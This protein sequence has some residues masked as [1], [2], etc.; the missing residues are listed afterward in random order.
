M[1]ARAG[2]GDDAEVID[3][4]GVGP[5]PIRG[6]G[7]DHHVGEL[8]PSSG[9]GAVPAGDD[10]DSSVLHHSPAEPVSV[11]LTVT[12]ADGASYSYS[13]AFAYAKS[14]T[15]AHASA[16]AHAL[17]DPDPSTFTLTVHSIGERAKR[18][19]AGRR[20]GHTLR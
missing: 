5:E 14:V 19:R 6:G 13:N 11:T 3:S 9:P 10:R 8:R 16:V 2:G 15:L 18:L 1:D 12:H 7:A 4:M 20:D 17:T